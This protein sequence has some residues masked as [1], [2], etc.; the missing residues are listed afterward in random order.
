MKRPIVLL[1]TAAITACAHDVTRRM[2]PIAGDTGSLVVRFDSEVPNANVSVNGELLCE[3]EQ[4]SKVTVDGVPVGKADLQI[5]ASAQAWEKSIDEKRSVD[6]KKNKTTS[7]QIATPAI[8]TGYWVYAGLTVAA[9]YLF[10]SYVLNSS[11]Q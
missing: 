10:N 1:A 6:V 3:D 11:S 2:S 5:N 7:V 8:S 9:V 4:T